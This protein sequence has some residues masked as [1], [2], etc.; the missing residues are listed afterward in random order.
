MAY[1]PNVPPGHFSIL[2]EM[3]TLLIAPMEIVGY[4][5]ADHMLPDVSQGRIFCRWLR[6]EWGIDTDSL[7][8]CRHNFEDGRAVF[9][10]AYPDDMLAAFRKHFWTVWLP[11]RSQDYFAEKDVRSLEYLPRLL[12]RTTAAGIPAPFNKLPP[13][14]VPK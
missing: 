6:D 8:T 2:V 5:L 13:R 12:A 10:K 1:H 4:M 9:P 7:P 11:E 3:T 14:P